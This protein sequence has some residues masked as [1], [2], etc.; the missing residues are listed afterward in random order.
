MS[1]TMSPPRSSRESDLFLP[2]IR[3][4]KQHVSAIMPE[5]TSLS[6]TSLQT[7]NVDNLIQV[8][9]RKLQE[10]PK[11]IK[12]LMLRS[13]AHIK[14]LMLQEVADWALV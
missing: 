4:L 1:T 7:I 6:E 2:Q 3:D 9:G 8:C 10:D 13:S 12:A 5:V 11:H 14:K